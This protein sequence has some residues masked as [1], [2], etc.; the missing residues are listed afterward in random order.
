MLKIQHLPTQLEIRDLPL[1][2]NE[3][4]AFGRSERIQI[5]VLTQ[6]FEY[7]FKSW[8][9][10][11][12][13]QLAYNGSEPAWSADGWSFAQVNLASIPGPSSIPDISH[14][15][16][17]LKFTDSGARI[18]RKVNVTLQ[19]P[20]IRGR[21]DCSL[22]DTLSNTSNWLQVLN[23]QDASYWNESYRGTSGIESFHSTVVRSGYEVLPGMIISPPDR[24]QQVTP[25]AF[26]DFARL[27][28]CANETDKVPGLAS[29]EYWS[30]N[31]YVRPLDDSDCGVLSM[32]T[33]NFTVK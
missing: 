15:F 20:A 11:A 18:D 16:G 21:I 30:C 10:G 27:V 23:F 17:A 8:V 1:I 9:N 12:V 7:P 31:N 26:A 14:E 33:G 13:V 25:T 4:F 2:F 32:L 29:I 19:T 5:P 28:C 6:V 24:L 22:H 3:P